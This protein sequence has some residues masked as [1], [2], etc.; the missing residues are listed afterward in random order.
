[1]DESGLPKICQVGI[2]VKDLKEAMKKYHS[3]LGAGPFKGY[4]VDSNELPGT[5]YRGKPADYRIKAAMA[6]L[7]AFQLELVESI[8]GDNIYKEF[9]EKHGEGVQHLGLSP[10][11]YDAAFAEMLKRGYKHIQG[12]PITGKNRNGRFDY[13]ETGRDFAVVLELL[14]FPE[15]GEDPAFIYP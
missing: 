14:D 3:L 6:Q 9:L 2:V 4:I 15:V 11:D 7:D 8:R 13:F 1:M 12:G 10:T 5:T